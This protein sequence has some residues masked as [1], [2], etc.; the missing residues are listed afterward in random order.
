LTKQTNYNGIPIREEFDYCPPVINISQRN[1]GGN[2]IYLTSHGS[3]R[4]PW[5]GPYC[6]AIWRVKYKTA[7]IE[8]A[9]QL[10]KLYHLR[11]WLRIQ[12]IFQEQRA[13][14]FEKGY[15]FMGDLSQFWDF[16]TY[17]KVK[18]GEIKLQA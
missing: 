16:D 18:T 13:I 5:S 1:M 12:I 3:E 2:Y 6:V 4:H 17:Y 15:E 7:F 11:E 8:T 14:G 9:K 10:H